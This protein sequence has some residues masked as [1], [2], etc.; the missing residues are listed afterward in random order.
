MNLEVYPFEEWSLVENMRRPKT[1]LITNFLNAEQAKPMKVR[2]FEWVW[3]AKQWS[4]IWGM[5]WNGH[6]TYGHIGLISPIGVHTTITCRIFLPETMPSSVFVHCPWPVPSLSSYRPPATLMGEHV[7]WKIKLN[8]NNL[9][10]IEGF[11]QHQVTLAHDND[12]DCTVNVGM[13]IQ[14]I[15]EFQQRLCKPYLHIY[16]NAF[17][18]DDPWKVIDVAIAAGIPLLFYPSHACTVEPLP[19]QQIVHHFEQEIS[20]NF[21]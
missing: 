13:S 20:L 15:K 7:R 18:L 1:E 4:L 8:Q 12:G 10:A 11:R 5:R 21:H 14:F 17:D 2:R 9:C 16:L 6:F 19:L 3:V